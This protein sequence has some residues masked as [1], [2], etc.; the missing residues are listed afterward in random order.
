M[1]LLIGVPIGYFNALRRPMFEKIIFF[2][3]IFFTARMEDINFLSHEWLR[4]TSKGFEVGMVDLATLILFM[5]VIKR[6]FQ[7]KISLPPGST[8][9]FLYFF[10]SMLS[11]RNAS[12]PLYSWFEVW[13]MMRM[14]TYFFT[15]YNY[16]R[17]E[18][19]L[20]LF[21]RCV[22]AITMYVFSE[23]V[24]QKYLFHQFQ[25]SGPF[26]HQNSLVMYMIIFGSIIFS[27]L[28][29]N[30]EHSLAKTIV[31]VGIFGMTAINIISTL[32]R[33]GMVLFLASIVIVLLMSFNAGYSSKKIIITI[34]LGF[35][36]LIILARAWDSITE[37]FE[38]A[39]EA[40]ANTRIDL[41]IAAQ[42]MA[43]DKTLGVGLN[44]FGIKINPPYNY[45]SHI[46]MH[47]EE[48]PDEQNGLVETIYLMIAAECG[49]HTLAIFFML[50][51]YFYFLNLRN[52]VRYRGHPYQFVSVA[53]LG[54]LLAIYLESVLEWV[55]KQTNNFYQLMLIFAIIS[56]MYRMD[57]DRILQK[58][59]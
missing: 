35:F 5:L 59:N 1:A 24:R 54:G 52:Y 55:L 10:F 2:L 43:N 40:S 37:R 27:Y 34:I 44:N 56:V 8:L 15:M 45:S 41:A 51:F 22:A 49:W 6:R 39:P 48:D 57:K 47:D 4:L 17:D 3:A 50:I 33:A 11:M 58:R 25:V 36:S 18:R 13:K 28:L 20:N 38:T 9:F 26:P 14:Y 19:T 30:K 29:N 12:D 53:F 7:Y 46:P 16:I 32:S 42:K 21:M 23:V 31:W